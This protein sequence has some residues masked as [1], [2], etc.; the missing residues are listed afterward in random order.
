MGVVSAPLGEGSGRAAQQAVNRV[1]AETGGVGTHEG[2]ALDEGGGE[3]RGR[4]VGESGSYGLFG[5]GHGP[6]GDM[7]AD[8]G[9]EYAGLLGHGERLRSGEDVLLAFV[10]V[11]GE[12]GGGH[13]GDVGGIDRG[14]SAGPY[15]VDDE[16][17]RSDRGQ[18]VQR[19][20]HEGARSQNRGWDARGA[21]QF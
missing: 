9:G 17:P 4:P 18:P 6:H 1:G 11:F 12:G 3:R 8:S 21:N 19:V 7:P 10:A 14:V 5:R 20:G 13:R 2:E 15:G 16:A